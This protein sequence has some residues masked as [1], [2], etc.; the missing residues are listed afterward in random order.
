MKNHNNPKDDSAQEPGK[1]QHLLTDLEASETAY[2]Q[3]LIEMEETCTYAQNIIETIREPLL[4]LDADLKVRSANR[5]FYSIF[6]V[7]PG[8]TV[9]TP[10]FDL[11]NRQWD[12]PR[13]R[14]LLEKILP[15]NTQ[16]DNFEVEHDFPNIGHKVMMLNARQ[17]YNKE[18]GKRMILLAMEDITGLRK[19]ETE[20]RNI[21][22]MF[23]HDMRNLL[24][25]SEGFLSRI[26]SGKAG[27]LTEKQQDH[28]EII[29]DE[30]NSFS[31]LVA[32]FIDFSK[33]EAHEYTPLIVP[34][35][36][37]A[38]IQKNIETAEM[39]AEKKQISI[40][41]EHSESA[42]FMVNADAAMISRVLRNLL[43]NAI[44]YTN[45]G[46][47]VSVRVTDR[48]NEI[49]VSVRDS[50]IGIPEDRLASIFDVFYRVKRDVEG[51]GLGLSIVKTI[52]EAHGGRIWVE[53]APEKGSVFSFTLPKP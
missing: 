39:A 20:R 27:P 41:L 50:G 43:D 21:L 18:P 3:A 37:Y 46:G 26:M 35:N 32:D 38:E 42:I 6:R 17:I 1:S 30:V 4:V 15:L 11:G 40:S 22:S 24:V 49:L 45:S 36:I 13:L 14:I 9:G 29:R 31:Q 34:F 33:F 19:L 5:S 51:F 16:F 10:I 12:I 28:L 23:A 53:S 8:E 48:G 44:K 25:T 47:T 2:R 7:N 52:I